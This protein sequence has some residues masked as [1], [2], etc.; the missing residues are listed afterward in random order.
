MGGFVDKAI[1]FGTLGIVDDASGTKA[2]QKA[3]RD[4][5]NAQLGAISAGQSQG[6]AD[7]TEGFEPA[8]DYLKGGFDGAQNELRRGFKPTLNALNNGYQGAQDALSSGFDSAR[9]DYTNGFGQALSG[10]NNAQAGIEAP[11]Q[12]FYDEGAGASQ[13]QAALS[14]ALGPQAQAQ[15]FQNYQESPEVAYMREM[16]EK[17]ALRGAASQGM[18]LSGS[19]LAELNRRGTGLAMQGFG[20]T[21]A[22][23]GSIANRG[24]AAGNSLAQARGNLATNTANLQQQQG[25]GLAN[26]NMQ[27]GQGLANLQG[28]QGQSQAALYQQQANN[29]A[30]LQS[31]RGQ[32]L[33]AAQLLQGQNLANISTGSAAQQAQIHGDLGVALGNASL[34]QG[35]M[36]YNLLGQAIGAGASAMGAA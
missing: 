5:T 22:R 31:G 19:V 9:G 26:M 4:A 12:N 2:A 11:I 34:A 29:L 7:L 6:R 8:M 24:Q 30:N 1:E 21:M 15:A 10:L 23:L 17:S 18:S 14:G 3:A 35:Q 25:Q 27:L 20:D 13:V 33:S 28:Q 36:G 16:G 32:A